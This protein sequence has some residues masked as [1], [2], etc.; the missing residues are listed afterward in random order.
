MAFECPV[1]KLP[2]S[3]PAAERA[4]RSIAAVCYGLI[5][6]PVAPTAVCTLDVAEVIDVTNAN[7]DYV[8]SLIDGGAYITEINEEGKEYGFSN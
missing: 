4:F 3:V 7:E 5:R 6:G 8:R 2:G 1:K